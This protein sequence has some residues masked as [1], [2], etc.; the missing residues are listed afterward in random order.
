M[1]CAF[2][3][4]ETYQCHCN[5]LV[6]RLYQLRYRSKRDYWQWLEI[7]PRTWQPKLFAARHVVPKQHVIR[8]HE[9]RKSLSAFVKAIDEAYG[10][11]DYELRAASELRALRQTTSAAKYAAEF[12]AIASNL[13]WNDSAV[14]NAYAPARYRMLSLR[15][16]PT[17]PV[18]HLRFP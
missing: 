12:Q 14:G 17:I 2:P 1:D 4:W 7:P 6:R 3:Q 8:N 10:D 16:C 11:P 13:S 5:G 18:S 15:L 9:L